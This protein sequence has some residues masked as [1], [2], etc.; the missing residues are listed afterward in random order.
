MALYDVN[1][2]VIISDDN[3]FD[4]V[5]EFTNTLFFSQGYNNAFLSSQGMC[6]DGTY[7]YTSGIRT[8]TL[9]EQTTTTLMRKINISNGSVAVEYVGYNY[10]HANGLAYDS[11]NNRLFV[12]AWDV[13]NNYSTVYIAN[14]STLEY[15]SSFDVSDAISAV[16]GEENYIGVCSCAY[17]NDHGKLILLVRGDYIGFAVFNSNLELESF[18]R[19]VRPNPTASLQGMSYKDNIIYVCWNVGDTDLLTA[20]D[21]N[22]NLI[23]IVDVSWDKEFEACAIV[24]DDWY[25]LF[26]DSTYKIQK[27]YKGNISESSKI[28]KSDIMARYSY[29]KTPIY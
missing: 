20:Y 25:F 5:E 23:Y 9:G 11:T 19:I 28:Y 15:V 24:G 27:I 3:K 18:M 21:Y 17:D 4:V 26:S 13:N 16:I 1:G 29:G 2:D 6:T 7:L 10:Q 8:N 12:V 14:P 22:G